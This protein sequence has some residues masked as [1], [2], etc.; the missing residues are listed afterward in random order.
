MAINEEMK[1][2]MKIL[3]ISTATKWFVM[4]IGVHMAWIK[5]HWPE[6]M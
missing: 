3:I 6:V 2:N 1:L 4:N 5:S